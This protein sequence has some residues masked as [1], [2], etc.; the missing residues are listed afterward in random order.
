MK[1]NLKRVFVSMLAVLSLTTIAN[2]AFTKT[3]TYTKGQFKDVKDTAWYEKEVSSAYELGF[4]NGT[5]SDVF[6]PDGNVTVAQ[7]ITIASRVNASYNGK[8]EITGSGKNWYDVYV[9]YAKKNGLITEN[10]FDDYNRNI[11]RAEMATLFANAV[12]EK[13]FAAKNDVKLIP[14]VNIAA[15]YAEDILML[16]KAGIVMG[17]DA[18]GTF[19]PDADIKRSEAAAIINRVAIPEN[20]LAKELKE[21]T[22]RDAYQFLYSDGAYDNPLTGHEGS[23]RESV[24]SGWLLDNRAGLP[25][26]N[27]ESTV[28]SVSD[29]SKTE[30]SALIREFNKIDKDKVVAEFDA[31]FF[32]NG[33]YFEFRDDKGKS[34]YMLKVIDGKWNILGKDGKFTAVKD[35][36]QFSK[37]KFRLYLDLTTGKSKTYIDNVF[38]GEHDL[39]SDN[40]L[41]FRYAIDEPSTGEIVPGEMNFVANYGVYEFFDIYGIEEVYGWK[42]DGNVDVVKEELVFS[43]KGSIEK[44]FDAIDTKYIAEMIAIF[45]NLETAGFKVMS[46]DKA[47]VEFKSENGKLYANGKEVY[48]LTKNMWY[49]LRVEANP[50]TGKAEIIVNGRTMDYVP[51]NTTNAVDK[52]TI[53]SENGK[54]VFDNIRVYNLAD[55]YDYVPVPEAKADL[56]DWIVAMNVCSLWRDNGIHYGWAVISPYDENKPVLGYYDEGN[57]ETADWEIKFMAE[58]GIDAQAFC[59]YANVANGPIK[60]PYLS[61]QLHDG[62]QVSK[63]EDYMKYCLIFEA[64]S[65]TKFDANQFRTHVIP[66]WFENYFLDENYLV[67]DNKPVLHLYALGTITGEKMFGSIANAKKEF[68]YLEEVAKS[69]GFD[70]MIYISNGTTATIAEIGADAHAAYHWGAEGYT[71]DANK[72]KNESG[73]KAAQATGTVYQIPTISVGY[74]DYAWRNAKAPLATKEEFSKS[75]KWV[76]ETYIPTYAKKGTWQERMVW[77]STWN[78]YGEGTYIMPCEGLHG[79]DYLDVIREE[80][81]NLPAKHEDVIPTEAQGERIQHLYPQYQRHLRRQGYYEA[82]DEVLNDENFEVVKKVTFEDKKVAYLHGIETISTEGGTLVAKST[83]KDFA[84]YF[85]SLAGMDTTKIEKIRIKMKIPAGMIAKVYYTT[86]ADPTM[87]ETK[88]LKFTPNSDEMT[89]YVLD[90]SFGT[91][92]KG[93]LKQLR[94]DPCDAEGLEFSIESIEFLKKV[95]IES[96]NVL[97]EQ[98]KL[99]VNGVHIDSLIKPE[100]PDDEILFPYD[101]ETAINYI[102]HSFINWNHDEKILTIEANGHKLVY[103]VGSDKYEIDGKQKNL[104]YKLYQVDGLPM[105]SY[106]TLSDALGY[107]YKVEK[108]K[109]Y[110]ETPHIE[111]Y[112]DHDDLK[113]A[114]EFNKFGSEGWTSGSVEMFSNGEYLRVDNTAKGNRDPNMTLSSGL[115]FSSEKY[116][117]IEVRMRYKYDGDAPSDVC[118]YF[119]TSLDKNW[120]EPKKQSVKLKRTDTQGEWEVYTLEMSKKPGWYGNIT[121]IRLDPFNASGYAEIDYIRLVENPDYDESKATDFNG[122]LNGDAE[123][124]EIMTMTSPSSKVSIVEDETKPGNHVYR[125]VAPDSKVWTYMVHAYPFEEGKTYKISFDARGLGDSKGNKTDIRLS[126]NIQYPSIDGQNHGAGDLNLT[127]DGAWH[128]YEKEYT[129]GKMLSKDGAKF[130]CYITPPTENSSG[131]FELDNLVVTEVK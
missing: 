92:W 84:L 127:A 43:G 3:N 89:E 110:V 48:T 41:N 105:I 36:A 86:E 78:E 8:G 111:L 20:R 54:P 103:T 124:V 82:P 12:P 35:A 59:W 11:T 67:I 98:H 62:Y 66:Y 97:P 4:M 5:A 64:G 108:G 102:M 128:H 49:R 88:T 15:S 96:E 76:K 57:P 130:S 75:H 117:N 122:I 113:T 51:L 95:E 18:Y 80:Y 65:G 24:T 121:A 107:K 129:I 116:T 93:T 81:T 68:D 52:L 77:L 90:T 63:Y 46:G 23:I 32:G 118:V 99:Y 25:R 50:S 69:H 72:S 119:I 29:Q 73:A 131:I 123:K 7:G 14:D 17:S 9:D 91:G 30:G 28:T 6:S 47:A 26:T 31:L 10:Q 125:A 70:G 101:P 56:S 79:F 27:I 109:V 61:D 21:Y 60:V 34:T 2:A 114:W 45:P 44:P 53:F 87:N 112:E 42:K 38:Y 58:H 16:Y 22:A 55:H 1:T 104:G 71:F 19:N 94:F 13:E 33:T 106:K 100:M 126:V 83:V 37:E 40:I 120:N 115:D 85:D 39:L 74:S